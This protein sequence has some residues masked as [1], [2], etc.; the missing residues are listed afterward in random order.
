VLKEYS[1]ANQNIIR[2]KEIT[3]Y[4]KTHN[5]GFMEKLLTF[6][7]HNLSGPK[8]RLVEITP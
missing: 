1:K 6:K 3:K 2:N 4:G 5:F 7:R 8:G